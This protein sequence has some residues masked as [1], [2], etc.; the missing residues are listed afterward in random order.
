MELKNASVEEIVAEL[1]RR[2][3][4]SSDQLDRIE[5]KL[6][7]FEPS[8]QVEMVA[9]KS[10]LEEVVSI[11]KN[12]PTFRIEPILP[13]PVEPEKPFE[14]VDIPEWNATYKYITDKYII[15][16]VSEEDK[17]PLYRVIFDNGKNRLY[18]HRKGIYVNR[19][20]NILDNPK[21]TLVDWT[22]EEVL[23]DNEDENTSEGGFQPSVYA[24]S[25]T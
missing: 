18:T 4:M 7:K 8:N 14:G 13:D 17:Y 20:K 9:I 12:S 22:K 6:D 19:G 3:T 2:S 21:V 23:V 11:L 25:L 1:K 24:P 16:Y 5:E 15:G 10:I